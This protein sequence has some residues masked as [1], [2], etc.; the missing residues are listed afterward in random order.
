MKNIE[1]KDSMKKSVLET[2]SPVWIQWG[3]PLCT[4]SPYT[5]CTHAETTLHLLLESL[6]FYFTKEILSF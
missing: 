3:H 4:P 1:A 2:S 5:P 6:V